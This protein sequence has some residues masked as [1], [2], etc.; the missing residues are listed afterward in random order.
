VFKKGLPFMISW[1]A[2]CFSLGALTNAAIR[3]ANQRHNLLLCDVAAV[4]LIAS[5]LLI[6]VTF[7]L[8]IRR[9][10]SGRLLNPG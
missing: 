1:W 5:T 10:L 2:S 9:Q 8:T 7:V 4:L 3:Y 6:A